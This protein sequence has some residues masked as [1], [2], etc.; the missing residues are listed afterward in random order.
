MERGSRVQVGFEL[1]LYARIPTEVPPGEERMVAVV[2]LWDRLREIAESLLPLAGADGR[3]TLDDL[4]DWHAQ[5][6]SVSAFG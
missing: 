3:V 1:S 4:R 6:D 2:A 5:M